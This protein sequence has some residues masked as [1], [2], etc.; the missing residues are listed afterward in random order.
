MIIHIDLIDLTF[1]IIYII[2]FILCLVHLLKNSKGKALIRMGYYK[3]LII[4]ICTSLTPIFNT[5]A[6]ILLI[7]QIFKED[8]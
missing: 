3:Y 1:L 5:I 4:I 2:S 6:S 8:L 7:I